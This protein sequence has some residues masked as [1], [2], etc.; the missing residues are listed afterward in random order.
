MDHTTQKV[1]RQKPRHR[2]C[3]IGTCS[4]KV[5][6]KSMCTMHY[7][8]NYKHGDPNAFDRFTYPADDMDKAMDLYASGIKADEISTLT[9]IP[10]R[11]IRT[12]A[13]TRKIKRRK[14]DASRNMSE[15]GKIRWAKYRASQT[16]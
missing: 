7:Q 4:R 12:A 11:Y 5:F 9:V 2:T 10:V 16:A 14:S 15:A 6:A 8:R 3:S 13:S 1:K